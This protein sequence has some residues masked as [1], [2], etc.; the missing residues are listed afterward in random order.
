MKT[1]YIHIGTPKTATTAI[2]KFLMNNKKALNDR[3][4][5]YPIFPYEYP[6]ASCWRNGHFLI[7]MAHDCHIENKEDRKELEKV[8]FAQAMETIRGLF[9]T[10]DNIILSDEIIWRSTYTSPYNQLWQQLK[11]EEK[12]G[13]FVVKIIVYL[14]RQDEYAASWWGQLVKMGTRDVAREPFSLYLE[15]PPQALQLDYFNKLEEIACHIERE[16]I[17]VRRFDRA[18]FTGNSIYADFLDTV[19]ITFSDE[20][21]ID[22]GDVNSGLK[23]NYIEFKRIINSLTDLEPTSNKVL[24]EILAKCADASMEKGTPH[25]LKQQEIIKL[26]EPYREGNRKIASLYLH[27]PEGELFDI[28]GEDNS[29]QGNMQYQADLVRLVGESFIYLLH[30]NQKLHEEV[31]H[32]FRMLLRCIKRSIF[33]NKEKK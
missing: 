12:K 17:L 28:N 14:R 6:D 11:E 2:Q 21:I 4:Y 23:G 3:G 22:A 5:E 27:E 9:L 20:F 29:S 8:Q 30:D 33:D 24:L 25:K 1:L 26:M 31:N 18:G 13:I 15:N 32:P 10:Y 7:G 16:H 19:G